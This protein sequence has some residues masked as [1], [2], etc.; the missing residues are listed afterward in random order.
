MA[1]PGFLFQTV[2]EVGQVML[3]ALREERIRDVAID[4]DIGLLRWVVLAIAR[5]AQD[6]GV[7]LSNCERSLQKWFLSMDFAE[8]LHPHLPQPY[9]IDNPKLGENQFCQLRI[10]E[11]HDIP[12]VVEEFTEL[13]ISLIVTEVKKY[14]VLGVNKGKQLKGATSATFSSNTE[15]LHG[16]RTCHEPKAATLAT[17]LYNDSGRVSTEKYGRRSNFLKKKKPLCTSSLT[18]RFQARFQIHVPGKQEV[19][20]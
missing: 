18:S 9:H 8:F 13:S 11:D 4:Q 12:W 20:L 17:I 6:Q 16:T 3:R 7:A 1:A 14:H 5:E 19:T 2:Y 15:P 10:L